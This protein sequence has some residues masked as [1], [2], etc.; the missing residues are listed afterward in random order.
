[1]SNTV[2]SP[3]IVNTLLDKL[4]SDDQFRE[5]FLGNPALTLHLMGV[6]IDPSQVPS[7]RRLPSKAAIQANRCAFA[8]QLEGQVGAFIFLVE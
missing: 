5:Q 6:D 3:Q 1:M 7:I 8:K 4:G 2:F